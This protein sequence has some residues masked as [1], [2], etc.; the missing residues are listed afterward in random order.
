M[1]NPDFR[2]EFADRAALHLLNE[3]AL[4]DN[5]SLARWRA[6]N[7]QIERAVVAESA[8]WGDARYTDDPVEQTN[9][10]NATENIAHQMVGNAEKLIGLLREAGYYPRLEP[11]AFN[12]RGG[13]V[14]AGFNLEMSAP[15][16]NIFFT[17]DGT[18]PRLSGSGEVSPAAQRYTVPLVLTGTTHIRARAL[19]MTGTGPEWSA[20]YEAT[21]QIGPPQPGLIRITEIMYNPVP[22]D[23][24]EYLTVS[25]T[26]AVPVSLAGA[27]FEGISYTFPPGTPLLLPG[28]ALTLA[29][30]PEYLMREHGTIN[31]FD[32][33][34]GQLSNGG[35]TIR[36]LDA[37]GNPITTVTYQDSN[38]WPVT[39][40]GRGDSLILVDLNGDP[41]DP[42]NWRA[43]SQG[44]TLP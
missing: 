13:S 20:Q 15:A 32:E 30:N 9:W 29:R 12:Q 10:L 28:E 21:F 23:D 40:D 26:G 27:S 39:A 11:P 42:K 6:I 41:N 35:E 2:L 44:I 4:S 33:F 24:G 3:G 43:S 16:G 18:D 17:I 19:A 31:V 25:N 14:D 1:E 8:R 5:S 36:L 22:S 34:S 7:Q 38:G 37:T